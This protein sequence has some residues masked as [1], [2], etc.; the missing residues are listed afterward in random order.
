MEQQTRDATAAMETR[1][2]CVPSEARRLCLEKPRICGC[3]I[4]L[5]GRECVG[6]R[7]GREVEGL[8]GPS[9]VAADCRFLSRGLC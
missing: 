1:N 8:R 2:R 4:T 3:H 7:M 9:K 6:L 5:H